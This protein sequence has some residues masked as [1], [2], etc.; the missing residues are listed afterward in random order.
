MTSKSRSGWIVR[1]MGAPIT[2]ASKL[3]T[4]TALSTTEAEYIALATS[5][6]KGGHSS[7]GDA[8]RS[9]CVGAPGRLLAA[10]S[11][12]HSIRR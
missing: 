6:I 11:A 9:N 7:D 2:W 5:V 4:I 8:Q 12:L 3:Q 10:K 1:Y